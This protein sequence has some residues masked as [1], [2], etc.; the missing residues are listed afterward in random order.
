MTGRATGVNVLEPWL[1][2]STVQDGI[3]GQASDGPEPEPE[4]APAPD[5]S[6]TPE[7]L[8][9]PEPSPE[10]EPE[11]A[12]SP[13]PEPEPA[14]AAVKPQDWRDRRIAQLTARL[15]EEQR[16]NGAAAPVAGAGEAAASGSE[17]RTAAELDALVEARAA[18]RA[19]ADSFNR[20]CNEAAAAGRA[21]FPDFD[22]RIVALKSLVEGGD[23]TDLVRYNQ[24]LLAAIETGEA[25][26]LLH[27]LGQDLN[28]ASRIM[29][30]SPVRMGIELARLAA[31]QAGEPSTAPRP[32]R[33]LSPGSG[34]H[35]RIAPSDPD[36]ADRLSTRE[37][38][39]RREAE[40]AS[41]TRQRA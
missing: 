2:I 17:T 34:S 27:S 12:P 23:A 33:A 13:E 16:K 21:A 6:P 11:P 18:E 32:I 31:K 30:L 25:P 5:P 15:R 3:R 38:M 36:R 20:Q 24:L 37:W 19:A 40:I 9:E 22:T 29:A 14:P 8:P 41:R 35:D 10:P 26:K 4:P 7:P 1:W 39:A 28:E